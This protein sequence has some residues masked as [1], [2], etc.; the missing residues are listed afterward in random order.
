MERNVENIAQ[1]P[2]FNRT[3]IEFLTVANDYC[4]FVEKAHKYKL[5]D[6]LDYLQKIAPLIYL[7]GSMLPEV[8]PENPDA[9]ERF[10]TEENWEIIFN[11]MRDKF[12]DKDHFWF[13]DDPTFIDTEIS[14]GSISELLADIYQDLK[15]FVML[16][17]K[18]TFNAKQNAVKSCKSLFARNWGYKSILLQKAIHKTLFI[19]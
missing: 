2:V 13:I 15:D 18:N 19:D 11:D 16:Y 17:Q 3:V 8:E 10:V 4:L 12:D 14:K 7:K 9:D 1:D 6:I 5:N